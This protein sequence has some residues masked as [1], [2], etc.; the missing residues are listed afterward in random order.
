MK[1]N[2]MGKTPAARRKSPASGKKKKAK[3]PT[4][5]WVL[6]ICFVVSLGLAV[7]LFLGLRHLVEAQEN[8][9]FMGLLGTS[10]VK[11][12]SFLFG[13]AA[14]VVP[15]M[16]AVWALHILLKKRC[17]SLSMAGF[18]LLGLVVLVGNSAYS[19]PQ[20]ITVLKAA[21]SGFGGGAVGGVLDW[22]LRRALGD[23]GI[24]VVLTLLS[25]LAVALIA[26]KSLISHLLPRAGA[27]ARAGAKKVRQNLGSAIFEPV[28]AELAGV[29]SR[30]RFN[31]PPRLAEADLPAAPPPA[32]PPSDFPAEAEPL[33]GVIV[34]P[35]FP[36]P[37]A[38][39]TPSSRTEK[40]PP[41]S[42]SPAIPAGPPPEETVDLSAGELASFPEYIKPALELL[43]DLGA[44]SAPDNKQIQEKIAI[45]EKTLRDF[46]I[47]A[48]VNQV[49]CGPA[50]TR[51]E[52][53]LAPGVKVSRVMSLSDDIQLAL[54]AESIRIEAPIPGKSAVGI[55]VPNQR[56]R[57][58]GLRTILASPAFTTAESPLAFALGE[59]ITG[60]SLVAKLNDMP[61]LLIA[62]STGSGKSVCLNGIIMSLLFNASPEEVKFI[63]IDPKMV[64]LTV[65]NGLP[66]LMTPVVT[67]PKRAAQILRWMT[68]EMEKRY[69]LFA[70]A[71]VR[72]VYRYREL[73]GETMPYIVVII[74]ELADLMMVAPGDVEDS[75]CR[76]AQMARAA[77]MHLIVATQRPSVDVVTG[78][79]KANIPSR[80]AFAVSSQI[81]S[82]TILDMSGAEKLL[83]KGD[84]LFLPVGL[85]K[86]CRV[87]GAFVSDQEI[88]KTVAF[89]TAQSREADYNSELEN[90]SDPAISL[91]MQSDDDL[92]AVAAQIVIDNQKASTSLLQRKLKLGYSRAARLMD[93]LEERG[94]VSAL[95]SSNKR[96]V[97]YAQEQYPVLAEA[98][99]ATDLTEERG[100]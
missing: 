25:L 36:S 52:V 66:H 67:D 60:Q 5:A 13:A 55:E 12:L 82:R 23:V 7:F 24:G 91:N 64:E 27:G 100:V 83:G 76:L 29:P 47:E 32:E 99:P 43:D 9:R 1:E 39:Q 14:W 3:K 40:N 18:S 86:P 59:T 96:K 26:Q 97:L 71:G 69:K 78:I 16:L 15:A 61:H 53:S 10:L 62:G 45:L 20:G 79:I 73:T 30:T 85:N 63:F 21:Q 54:A 4:S 89:I 94:V 81:D 98:V 41:G 2:F 22:L 58:V 74:D 93:L 88:E 77:G 42:F 37:V 17:W 19:V 35:V 44:Q 92:L 38:E 28:P 49:S 87:Q 68:V 51:Y 6:D 70:E 8:W 46:N 75:I 57:G 33:A 90:L 56:L 48:K 34:L 95:D 50:V 11:L 80:I 31:M 65:Y 72:D 84:M